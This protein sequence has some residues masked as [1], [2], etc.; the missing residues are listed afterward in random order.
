VAGIVKLFTMPVAACAG[1]APVVY[2]KRGRKRF[3]PV[4]FQ[5]NFA[6]NVLTLQG[7]IPVCRRCFGRGGK[8]RDMAGS[9]YKKPLQT[10]TFFAGKTIITGYT[11]LLA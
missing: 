2:K 9:P 5:L 10:A 7:G 3:A 8:R 1:R 4:S 6:P 11:P